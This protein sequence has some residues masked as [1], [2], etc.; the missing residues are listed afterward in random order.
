MDAAGKERFKKKAA[1]TEDRRRWQLW[2]DDA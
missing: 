1:Q 2:D